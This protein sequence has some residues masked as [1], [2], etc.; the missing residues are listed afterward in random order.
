MTNNIICELT[1]PEGK[2][3]VDNTLVIPVKNNHDKIVAILEVTELC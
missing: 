3:K 2:Y 1:M